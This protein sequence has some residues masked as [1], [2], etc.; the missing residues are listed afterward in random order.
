M[1][2]R[3]SVLWEFPNAV[4]HELADGEIVYSVEMIVGG[5][6]A[7]GE[8]ALVLDGPAQGEKYYYD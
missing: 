4:A 3:Q 2:D 8:Y 6:D 5:R 7:R 1:T